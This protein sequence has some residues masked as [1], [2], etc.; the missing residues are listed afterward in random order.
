M[1]H[2][3]T[4]TYFVPFCH[5]ERRKY[6]H[7]TQK[8]KY[9]CIGFGFD[10]LLF[11]VYKARTLTFFTEPC[12]Q[13]FLTT[14]NNNNNKIYPKHRQEHKLNI[15][16]SNLLPFNSHTTQI[17]DKDDAKIFVHPFIIVINLTNNHS[18]PLINRKF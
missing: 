2:T 6:R 16:P 11:R 10:M 7:E 18:M 8:L 1:R 4:K 12:T 5:A 15:H 13:N 3:I 14:S 17:K 9:M